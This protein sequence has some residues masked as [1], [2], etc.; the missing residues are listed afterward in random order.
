MGQNSTPSSRRAFLNRTSAAAALSAA[1]TL[2]AKD[3]KTIRPGVSARSASRAVG[4]NDRIHVGMIGVGGMGTVHLQAFMKQTDEEKLARS[5]NSP[6][7]MSITT[8]ATCWHA[9]TW[10]RC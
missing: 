9:T 6:T 7:R 1:S 3:Q 4:A 5:P 2:L 10:T 8:I